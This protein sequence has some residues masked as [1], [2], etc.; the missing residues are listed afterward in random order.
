[1]GTLLGMLKGTPLTPDVKK[2]IAEAEKA[3][4][5]VKALESKTE[6]LMKK[7]KAL[8]AEN[9]RLQAEIRKL[10]TEGT[11]DRQRLCRLEKTQEHILQL[12]ARNPLITRKKISSAIKQSMDSTTAHLSDLFLLGLIHKSVHV[13]H[14][15]QAALPDEFSITPEGMEYLEARNLLD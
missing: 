8:E 2:R 15:F 5:N 7:G 1:M 12:I 6:S 10:K 9:K 4:A 3:L 14:M 13:R 11:N